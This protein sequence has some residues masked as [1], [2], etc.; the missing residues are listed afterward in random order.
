MASKGKKKHNN[1]DTPRMI[2]VPRHANGRKKGNDGAPKAQFDFTTL[3]GLAAIQCTDAEIAVMLDLD[4]KT[5]E[6]AKKDPAFQRALQ[7]GRTH[8]RVSLRRAQYRSAQRNIAMQIFL[9]KVHLGQSE[10]ESAGDQ[11]DPI[12]EIKISV[13]RP[14]R[15]LYPELSR[16]SYL[17]LSQDP[18]PPELE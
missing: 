3:K 16:D 18:D 2:N 8:G 14:R 9:G 10:F 4:P 13:I 5:I 6:R 12:S 1:A 17:E 11:G 7:E 15:D